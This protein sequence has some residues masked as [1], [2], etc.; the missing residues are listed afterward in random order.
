MD[1]PCQSEGRRQK[2]AGLEVT[3]EIME[4]Q[5]AFPAAVSGE[6]QVAQAIDGLAAALRGDG[7]D[8]ARALAA[9]EAAVAALGADGNP[10][11][12]A[13]VRGLAQVLR[14]VQSGDRGGALELL[15]GELLRSFLGR[16]DLSAGDRYLKDA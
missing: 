11:V 10:R 9:A 1:E 7:T 15:D 5:H 4:R 2:A 6:H 14:L 12:R 3:G 16:G 8:T 13:Q